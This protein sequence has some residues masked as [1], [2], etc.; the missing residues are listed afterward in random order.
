MIRFNL[1][2]LILFHFVKQYN[3]DI[4]YYSSCDFSFVSTSYVQ[5]G[6]Q[7]NNIYFIMFYF[8]TFPPPPGGRA[9]LPEYIHYYGYYDQV[10]VQC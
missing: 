8:Y 4:L 9:I 3:D 10:I 5:K 2:N 6:Q 7:T 1:V